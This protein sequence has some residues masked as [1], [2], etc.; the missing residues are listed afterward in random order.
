MDNN[1]P[2]TDKT[3][4]TNKLRRNLA[5]VF[6]DIRDDETYTITS[7]A[8]PRCV[9]IRPDRFERLSKSDEVCSK[10]EDISKEDAEALIEAFSA[11]EE[12]NLLSFVMN[13]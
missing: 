10:F 5:D 11:S 2:L 9:M 13:S 1:R 4:D 8:R 6:E 3:V 7:H 12:D